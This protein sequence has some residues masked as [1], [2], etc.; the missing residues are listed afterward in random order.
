M[1]ETG[2]ILGG[3]GYRNGRFCFYDCQGVS[4]VGRMRPRFYKVQTYRAKSED[5]GRPWVCRATL[6]QMYSPPERYNTRS[7]WQ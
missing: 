7:P 4:L 2:S 1:E 6:G 3:D 5:A